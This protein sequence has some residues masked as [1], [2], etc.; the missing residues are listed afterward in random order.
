MKTRTTSVFLLA[1]LLL[2]P[3]MLPAQ[4][5][6]NP[7]PLRLGADQTGHNPFSGDIAT[8]RLYSR[9]LSLAEIARL[10]NA[11]PEAPSTVSNLVAEWVFG[12]TS[13]RRSAEALTLPSTTAGSLALERVHGVPCAHFGGGSVTVADHPK[14]NPDRGFT[15]EAW[16]RPAPGAN[17]RIADKITPGGSDGWLLDTHPGSGLRFIAGADTLAVPYAKI[18][19]SPSATG[20]WLHVVATVDAA[21]AS[22]LFAQGKRLLGSEVEA[23]V[24]LTGEAPGPGRPLTLWY[25][26]P[27]R[28]WVEASV[29]G[30]GRLGGMVWGGVAQE[31]IGLNEDTLWSGEPYNNLNTNGLAAVPQ[32]RALLLA[33]KNAQAQG[34]IERDLNGHYDQC[35]QPLGDLFVAFPITGEVSNY[36]RELDLE[37][38]VARTSFTYDGARIT[39]EVFASAPG[40]A[41]I[42][43]FTSDHPGRTSFTASL[44]SQLHHQTQAEAHTLRVTGRAPA[45]AD[46]HYLAKRVVYDD[47]P[48]GKGMRFEMR[49]T[50]TAEGGRLQTSNDTLVAK[51]CDNVTLTLVAATSFNGPHRSPS[52]DGK[53][54]ARQCE[55]WLAAL[56]GKPYAALRQTHIADHQALFRR[57]SLDLGRS[58]NDSLPT[59]LRLR[60]YQPGADPALA[61]LY[62]QFGRYLLIAGSRPGTQPLN[63]QGI[64][65]QDINPA[66]SANWTLNCN[67]EINYWPVEAANLAECHE[68]LIDLTTQLSEDGTNI[69]RNLYGARGWVAHHNTD[70]WR[71]AGPV[72]GSACWSIF[73]VGSA[74]LCQHL[75]EHYAFSGDTNYLRRAW[76][77]LSGAARYYL[78]AMIEEPEHHWLVTA[79]DT[80]FE[81][82]FRKPNGEHSCACMG[83]TASMQ[84]VRELFRNCLA[85]SRILGTD[86]AFQGELERALPRLAPMQVS[87]TTGELQEWVEDWQRTAACQV[88]SS[89][90]AVCSA[91]ITPR[92]TPD[93]AAGLRKIFDTAKWWRGGSVG[94][95]QGSFQANVYARFGD[96][97]TA[98]EVLETHLK[99]SVNPNL[100]A[101][102]GG[103][104]DF[105]IDGNL[106]HTAAI[107]EMLLQSQA[108][109]IE[110][111]PALPKTWP[112]GKV[113]GL[114]ARGAFEVDEAWQDGKLSS[115][116]LRSLNGGPCRV[117]YGAKVVSLAMRPGETRPL[118]EPL[119][120]AQ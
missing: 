66:W 30:N 61:A 27:A 9:A 97:D 18:P 47:A 34:M 15:V 13:S 52:A 16:I 31:H 56:A 5:P 51:G 26:Q 83:P 105:Q 94:S 21:G 50:A 25:R 29:I 58:L 91:Q 3:P 39:R 14:L 120:L 108:G 72:S 84:M 111:L 112:N 78:D 42:L 102:F 87:P 67:A 57:V 81:N 22:S 23:G 19:Y 55:N 24:A 45:Q 77:V 68:P 6:A 103:Y 37:T 59:D 17:G 92:G 43:R 99:H 86:A 118:N 53:D 33:G 90:G 76:P 98:G 36:C 65:N 100:L 64:W 71:Q 88:L 79:P 107:G 113:A 48:N 54:P 101:R 60:R 69:A 117:R 41:I 119:G 11:K 7:L 38:A 93:L 8:V 1:A 10:A 4:V 110:L 109:E 115:A 80:N 44:G 49:L 75:W 116:R 82:A 40:Q 28:R 73:Q 85:A 62:Y 89:W 20:A 63:L 104:C 106:G 46:P 12:D 96:G 2:W 95:W 114:R 74:W 35:Y 70:I 32:I